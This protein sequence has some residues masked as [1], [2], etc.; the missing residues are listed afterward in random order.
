ME[1]SV[2]F[3]G[4]FPLCKSTL[5][6][7]TLCAIGSTNNLMSSNHLVICIRFKLRAK[8]HDKPAGFDFQPSIILQGSVH[9]VF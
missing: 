1:R 3:Q 6:P 2:E 4:I 5:S 7:V 9:S 8:V